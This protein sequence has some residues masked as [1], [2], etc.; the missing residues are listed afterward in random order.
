MGKGVKNFSKF[1]ADNIRNLSLSRL[2][3]K[4]LIEED[5]FGQ[6]RWTFHKHMLAGPDPLINVYVPCDG[7][8]DDL[9]HDLS[10]H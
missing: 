7:T 1:E 5:Q 3:G 10:W 2:V 4:P 9:L 6:A 8:K